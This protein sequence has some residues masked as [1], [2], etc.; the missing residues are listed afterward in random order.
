MVR[1]GDVEV[2]PGPSGRAS[3]AKGPTVEEQLQTLQ[4]QASR[5]HIANK[6]IVC[7]PLDTKNCHQRQQINFL[8]HLKN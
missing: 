1:V 2:N 5:I 3:V 4:T 8:M 7:I 6:N